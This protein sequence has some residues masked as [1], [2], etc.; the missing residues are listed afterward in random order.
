MLSE[1]FIKATEKYCTYDK[2]VAAPYMR[3]SFELGVLPNKAVLTLTSTGFYRLYIN[4]EE[5]TGSRLAPNITNPDQIIFFDEY[6]VL[7][8]LKVGKNC[9]ALWLGNGNGNAIGGYIWGFDRAKYRSAPKVALHF[10]SDALE[11]EADE[12][13]VCAPSPVIFDDLR[14]GEHY[15]ARKEIEGWNLPDFDDSTWTKAIP[16]DAARGVYELNDT[17]PIVITKELKPYEVTECG[18]ADIQL[19]DMIRPDTYEISKTTYY[20]PAENE[21]GFLFKFKDNLSSV[22]RLRIKGRAGQVIAI[23]AA[24]LLDENGDIA[25]ENIQSFYPFGFCQ[26]DIYIC[27]GGEEIEEYI[28]SFTYHG[29]K[30][31]MVIGIDKEQITDDTLTALVLNS[32]LKER[33]GF[34]C[35]DYITNELMRYGRNSDLANFVYFPMD[36]PHREKNGWTG[37]AAVSAEHMLQML[38]VERSLRQ[39]LKMIRE[40]QRPN[41]QIPGYIPTAFGGFKWG[42]GPAWDQVMIEIPYQVYVY[43]GDKTLFLEC[44]D[45]LMHYL[46]YL[47]KRRSENGTINIG[48][49]DYCQALRSGSNHICPNVTTDTAVSYNICR[50]AEFMFRECGLELQAD[51]AKRLGDEFFTAFHRYLV[52]DGSVVYGGCQTAQAAA[53]YYGL[54]EGKDSTTAY[55]VL[56]DMIHEMGDHI[57]CGMIGL[58]CIF[59][60]L[61]KHGDAELAYKMITRTDCPSYGMWVDKY[62]LGSFA[63]KFLPPHK[64]MHTSLNHHFHGDITGFFIAHIAGLQINPHADNA[65]YVR[66]SP[67]FIEK[68]THASAYYD[69]IKGRV[70]VRWHRDGEKIILKVQMPE[71]VEGCMTLPRGWRVASKEGIRDLFSH[72]RRVYNIEST[73]YTVERITAYEA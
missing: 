11:F 31:Y 58:R 33:G 65:G 41:G 49:G 7:P 37:D 13:F 73:T 26:R 18:I 3:K 5:I 69:T 62:E 34:E 9:I 57:D 14:S 29:A 21:R 67:N 42:N 61:A 1:R 8:Y 40:V 16:T 10:E 53:L 60:V 24:E 51:F 20:K 39:W 12:S 36:C 38:T 59:R 23:Q 54:F 25:F 64:I 70:E 55:R 71:G 35:S 6:D 22:P 47:S 27:K 63:E 4:G 32:D 43:R 72:N 48:L 19:P 30:Y 15:D 45:M 17:D 28:P 46:N 44:A 52:D 56:L 50:K 66:I 68:L 2:P